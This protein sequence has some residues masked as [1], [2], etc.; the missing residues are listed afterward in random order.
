MKKILYVFCMLFVSSLSFAWMSEDDV[1]TT[2]AQFLKIGIGAK[3]MAMGGAGSA[4]SGVDSLYWNPAGLVSME[5]R[6]VMLMQINW[7]EEVSIQ[8]LGA[9][10]PM[11]SGVFGLSYTALSIDGLEYREID[12]PSLG[13]FGASDSAIGLSYAK[14]MGNC[15]TGV[16]LKSIQSKIKDDSASAI[17]LDIGLRKNISIA[18]KNAVAAL[19]LKDFG[20]GLKFVA[21]EDPLPSVIKIGMAVECSES[22][23]VAAD[24]NLPSDNKANLNIGIEYMLPVSAIRFPLRFGYK[25]LND[26]DAMDGLSAGFGIGLNNYSFDFAW[27]P[28]GDLSDTYRLSLSGKF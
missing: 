24:L 6:E 10:F 13:T 27:V 26:F 23:S 9:A 22:L 19:V 2:G 4:V 1:G 18:G 5:K 12:G 14:K 11:A 25:T 3:S 20:T 8:Y 17:A 21:E 7:L 15:E 16:T 28:Y